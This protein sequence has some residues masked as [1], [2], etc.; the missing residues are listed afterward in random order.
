MPSPSQAA[1]I[2]TPYDIHHGDADEIVPLSADHRLASI[3]DANGVP[4]ELFIYPGAGHP[5][6]TPFFTPTFYAR[7]HAWYAKYGLF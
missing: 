7:V 3:L 2:G 6:V 4:Y 5:N 1:G